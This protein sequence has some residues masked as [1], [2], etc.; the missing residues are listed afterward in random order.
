[1]KGCFIKTALLKQW[2]AKPISNP[3]I[4]HLDALKIYSEKHCEKRRNC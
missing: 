1:M 2:I 4:P 3:T